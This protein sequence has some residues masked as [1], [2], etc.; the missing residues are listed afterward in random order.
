MTIGTLSL[1][2]RRVVAADFDLVRGVYIMTVRYAI[3]DSVVSL[4]TML[5]DEAEAR[6]ALAKIDECCYKGPLA[7]AISTDRLEL[8]TDDDDE[9]GMIGFDRS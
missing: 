9:E 2:P 8:D 1:D 5:T 7:D 3:G 4:D 6:Y